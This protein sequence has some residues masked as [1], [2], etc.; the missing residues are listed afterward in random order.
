MTRLALL[1]GAILAARASCLHAAAPEMAPVVP[2]A[3]APDNTWVRITDLQTG[4]RRGS[5]FFYSEAIGRFVVAQ[6]LDP[7]KKVV[8]PYERRWIYPGAGG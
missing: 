6:G 4:L 2:L 3:R 5:A 8:R 1:A 7:D